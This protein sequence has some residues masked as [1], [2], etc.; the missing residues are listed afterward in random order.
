[1]GNAGQLVP[2]DTNLFSFFTVDSNLLLAIFVVP[3]IVYQILILL[4]KR[5]DIPTFAYVLKFIGT[6]GTSLTLFTVL[7]YLSPLL[8]SQFWKLFVNTN[9]FFHLIVPVLGIVSFIFFEYQ[10][11]IKRYFT[12]VGVAP[13]IIYGTWYTINALTHMVDGLVD[14]KY[15]IY[16]FTAKGMGVAAVAMIVMVLFTYLLS[17]LLYFF[18]KKMNEKNFD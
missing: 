4:K 6:V 17:F 14:S 18:N 3:M 13:M 1:M 2:N 15:D 5:E 16:G 12:Y 7:F 11:E 9:L 8:G 10:K